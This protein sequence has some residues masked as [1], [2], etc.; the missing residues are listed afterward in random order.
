VFVKY[1]VK[2]GLLMTLRR[3]KGGAVTCR[4][5]DLRLGAGPRL[6]TADLQ[7]RV[8]AGRGPELAPEALLLLRLR[9]RPRRRD[10]RDGERQAGVPAVLHAELRRGEAPPLCF[11]LFNRQVHTNSAE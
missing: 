4:S 6:S 8:H 11:L 9:L 1:E 5:H 7:Q 10:V 2:A 3:F